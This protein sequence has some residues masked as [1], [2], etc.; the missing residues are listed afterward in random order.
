[1]GNLGY[2]AH[3]T[4]LDV[5]SDLPLALPSYLLLYLPYRHDDWAPWV[6]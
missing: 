3:T 2:K 5:T 6:A 4:H 1:M